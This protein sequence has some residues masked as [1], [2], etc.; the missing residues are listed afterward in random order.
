MH[1]ILIEILNLFQGIRPLLAFL[2]V[3]IVLFT[4]F[5]ADEWKDLA[6][7]GL[8]GQPRIL[9]NDKMQQLRIAAM[10]SDVHVNT[11]EFRPFKNVKVF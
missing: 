8:R 2:P 9:A 6:V 5:Q 10:S 1:S 3:F 11:T 7:W 4:H